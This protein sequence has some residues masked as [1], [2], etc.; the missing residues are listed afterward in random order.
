MNFKKGE[1]FIRNIIIVL[2]NSKVLEKQNEYSKNVLLKF[3]ISKVT[4]NHTG[5]QI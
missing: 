1:D 3:L 5:D 4:L 2:S